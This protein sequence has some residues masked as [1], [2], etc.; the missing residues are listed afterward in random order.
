ME[1]MQ[2]QLMQSQQMLQ[3]MRAEG[4]RQRQQAFYHEVD[5]AIDILP[6]ALKDNLGEGSITSMTPGSQYFN[7]RVQLIQALGT[8]MQAHSQSG[9]SIPISDAVRSTAQMMFPDSVKQEVKE[10]FQ[11]KVNE[12]QSQFSQRGSSRGSRK[13]KGRREKALSRMDAWAAKEGLLD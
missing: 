1:G 12:R 11:E 5:N 7:V 9:R 6:N 4:E 10:E 8:M 2:Q 13:A 3:H